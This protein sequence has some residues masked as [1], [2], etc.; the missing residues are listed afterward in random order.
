LLTRRQVVDFLVNECGYP[1]SYGHF[2]KLAAPARGEGP[3][4]EQWFN[5]RPLYRPSRVLAWA[6]SRTEPAREPGLRG[7]GRA[8]EAVV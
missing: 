2:Q 8:K 1:M 3:P 7:A 5:G 6:K 4:I